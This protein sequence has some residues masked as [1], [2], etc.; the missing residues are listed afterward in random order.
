MH[1]CSIYVYNSFSVGTTRRT[2]LEFRQV[3]LNFIV[4]AESSFIKQST[5]ST[6]RFLPMLLQK[7]SSN[8]FLLKVLGFGNSLK[9]CSPPKVVSSLDHLTL[10]DHLERSVVSLISS[11]KRLGFESRLWTQ[12]WSTEGCHGVREVWVTELNFCL[13]GTSLINRKENY[14]PWSLAWWPRGLSEASVMV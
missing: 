2:G 5:F 13:Q 11:P 6:S 3:L 4:R 7:N 9:C 12:Q 1:A 8:F 10:D 14:W